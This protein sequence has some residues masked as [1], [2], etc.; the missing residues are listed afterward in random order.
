MAY[1]AASTDSAEENQRFA[2][3]LDLDYP[4]LSDPDGKAAAAL[5]VLRE[6]GKRAN[7]W[8]FYIDP[9][10]KILHIDRDVK[11]ATAGADMVAHLQ[12]LGAPRRTDEP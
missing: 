6:D 2:Q 5:G 4:I 12:S 1:F 10:G 9:A 11:A 3:S 7:R 8:T